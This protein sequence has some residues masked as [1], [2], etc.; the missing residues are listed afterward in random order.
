[1]DPGFGKGEYSVVQWE[2]IVPGPAT[3]ESTTDFAYSADLTTKVYEQKPQVV[4]R[5][6]LPVI[7]H[8]IT[9]KAP[10]TGELKVTLQNLCMVLLKCIGPGFVQNAT[11]LSEE[12]HKKLEKLTEHW[13][14][15]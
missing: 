7:W 15:R 14:G 12:D 8:H 9:S 3:P 1:M 6:V 13:D 5:L 2:G 10:I 4:N 11:H